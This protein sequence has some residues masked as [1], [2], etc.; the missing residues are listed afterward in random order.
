MLQQFF[1][2][3]GSLPGRVRAFLLGY[4]AYAHLPA[5]WLRRERRFVRAAHD[6]GRTLHDAAK[7]A[8]FV[9]FDAAGVV[10][11]YVLFYL[12]ALRT[13]G[14]EIVLISNGQDLAPAAMAQVL[15][16]CAHVLARD[17]IGYDFAAYRD[18]LAFLGDL[19]RF[20]TVVLANDSVYGPL[21]DLRDILARCDPLIEV[22]GITDS[23]SGRYHLQSYFLLLQGEA[24]RNPCLARF[25]AAVLPIQ[26]KLWVVRHYETGFSQAMLRGGL[27]CGA[28]FAY[29]DAAA[30][31][32]AA[33]R[34]GQLSD[35]LLSPE[36]HKFLDW[37]CQKV[38]RGRPLNPM[39][40][41][42]DH[43]IS[44]MHC[45]FVKRELLARNPASIPHAVLWEQV[46]RSVSSYDTS[47]I[48][49]DLQITVARD[50][51]P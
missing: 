1:L 46:I 38:Q 25:F 39:H 45:P 5:A 48:V 26:S 16:M 13:A 2:L 43:L 42:W 49:R 31:L 37:I 41:L 51:A 34:A 33:A 7:V 24:L 29:R 36:L 22:W 6:G 47:L 19:S 12:A 40:H 21:F 32:L 4:L 9:H 27:R 20:D 14:F 23:W 44:H 50:R 18:G 28:L 35:P 17:N 10:Q 30:D 11:D 15:P 8:V 3:A